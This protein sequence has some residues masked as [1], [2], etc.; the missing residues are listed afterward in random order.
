MDSDQIRAEFKHWIGIYTWNGVDRFASEVLKGLR[1]GDHEP[2]A[3]RLIAT[4]RWLC[5]YPEVKRIMDEGWGRSL[6]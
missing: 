4:H 6:D 2:V 3:K 1:R 5:K